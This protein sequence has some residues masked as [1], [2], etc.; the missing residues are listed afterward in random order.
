MGKNPTLS[1]IS[2]Y[3]FP[4]FSR[5]CPSLPAPA[6]SYQAAL[7]G[8]HLCPKWPPRCLFLLTSLKATGRN[9]HGA[10]LL[11]WAFSLR[12]RPWAAQPSLTFYQ[13]ADSEL[14]LYTVT[15]LLDAARRCSAGM[16]ASVSAGDLPF[17]PTDLL[18]SSFFTVHCWSSTP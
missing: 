13:T 15:C 11:F 8:W 17:L 12:S 9:K 5:T 2:I 1:D 7:P 3:S 6:C 16:L 14:R 18:Y 10:L 4:R